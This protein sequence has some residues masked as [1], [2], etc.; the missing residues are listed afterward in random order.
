M[1]RRRSIPT[2]PLAL[3]AATLIAL[4]QLLSAAHVFTWAFVLTA[5]SLVA[6]TYAATQEMRANRAIEIARRRSGWVP[7]D[8]V[9]REIDRARR[10]ERPPS[11]ARLAL[12]ASTTPT[13][14][15]Q[16]LAGYGSRAL[17][18]SS[19]RVWR[20]GRDIYLL[21]PDTARDSAGRMLRRIVG[22]TDAVDMEAS[23]IVA[24]PDDAITTGAVFELL[25]ASVPAPDV[26]MAEPEQQ[27]AS[28]QGTTLD[29]Q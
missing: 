15:V 27:L 3:A 12:R 21:L 22:L 25:G 24:F 13:S 23:R 9:R 19:D 20:Q 26:V 10:Q 18:R 8:E 2:I 7:L 6:T 17:I 11:V 14:I 16:Q 28:V 1:N 29:R 5:F 4:Q